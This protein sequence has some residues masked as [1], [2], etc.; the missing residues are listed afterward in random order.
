[1]I[2]DIGVHDIF[3]IDVY[4]FIG[5]QFPLGLRF[6][7]ELHR[8]DYSNIQEGIMQDCCSHRLKT[9][10]AFLLGALRSQ[11]VSFSSYTISHPGV[12]TACQVVDTGQPWQA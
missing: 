2:R 11:V 10:C 8:Y 9:S 4:Q 7:W 12:H 1:M 3:D 6:E 5:M